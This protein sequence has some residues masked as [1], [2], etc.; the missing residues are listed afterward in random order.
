[1]SNV[2]LLNLIIQEGNIDKIRILWRKHTSVFAYT[3]V[4]HY[5]V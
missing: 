4:Q 3:Y 1:M 2:S 5:V